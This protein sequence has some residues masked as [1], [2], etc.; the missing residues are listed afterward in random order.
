MPV[1]PFN[2]YFIAMQNML[3]SS[4]TTHRERH[5]FEQNGVSTLMLFCER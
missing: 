3:H 2:V 5:L 4:F 1:T